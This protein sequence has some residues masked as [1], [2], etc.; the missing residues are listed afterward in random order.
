MS[1]LNGLPECWT[2]NSR[3]YFK[4]GERRKTISGEMQEC[5]F[6]SF[7]DSIVED[8]FF[9]VDLKCFIDGS[10]EMIIGVVAK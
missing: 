10:K 9:P 2:S 1:L 8:H 5:F 6:F 7:G 3:V 4:D